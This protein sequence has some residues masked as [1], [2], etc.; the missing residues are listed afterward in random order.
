MHQTNF[1]A[2]VA[3]LVVKGNQLLLGRRMNTTHADFLALPGGQIDEGENILATAKRELHEETALEMIVGEVIAITSTRHKDGSLFFGFGVLC[4]E[5]QGEL[6]NNEPEK[7]AGWEFYDLS[8]LPND[9][10]SSHQAF[11]TN[12]LNGTHFSEEVG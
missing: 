2:G 12:Y 11:I 4:S 8:N 1:N 7:C 5:Y 6:K 9:I 10:F 3:I